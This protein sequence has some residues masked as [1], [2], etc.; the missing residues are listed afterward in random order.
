MAVAVATI[1]KPVQYFLGVESSATGRAWRD[2]L[3]ER[4]KALAAAMMQRYSLPDLLARIIAGRGIELD[5]VEAFLDPSIRRLMPDPHVLTDMA[6]AAER[7]AEAVVRGEQ[8]AMFGDYDVDGATATALLTR[9]LR[10]GGSEPLI[11]IPDRI[12]EG[13]GPNVE[14]IRSLAQRGATLLITVD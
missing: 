7:I 4:S 13:Y 14:A 9:F 6:A 8:I 5:E 12:F 1:P 3:N 10:F 11:H 2:R